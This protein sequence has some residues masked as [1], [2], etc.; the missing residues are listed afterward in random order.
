MDD[1]TAQETLINVKQLKQI[2]QDLSITY[3]AYKTL[4]YL[5]F[6]G[7]EL[8]STS[9]YPNQNTRVQCKILPDETQPTSIEGTFAV[10]GSRNSSNT[11]SFS[12]WGF[13][14]YMRFDYNAQ[15]KQLNVSYKEL[16]EIDCNKNRATINSVS[17][18]ATSGTFSGGSQLYI[19]SNAN[20]ASGVC[21]SNKRDIRRFS[22]K[23]YYFK[24]YDNGTLV[25]DFVPVERIFDGSLGLYD[26]V[27]SKLYLNSA[28]SG[29]FSKGPE[30]GYI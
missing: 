16:L 30:T 25:R 8:I 9:F 23:L 29:N 20:Q 13:P 21:D 22:G 10:F 7:Y 6:S 24:I 17:S 14:T 4:E 5:V 12:L 11:A 28:D 2:Y 27:N 15:R 3:K 26:R 19:A 1:T 18:S